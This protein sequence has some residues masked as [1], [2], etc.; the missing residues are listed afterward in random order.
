MKRAIETARPTAEA[1]GLA[2]EVEPWMRELEEWWIPGGPEG[3]CP[4][5]QVDGGTVRSLLPGLHQENWHS[6][7]PFDRPVLCEGF[8]ELRDHSAAFFARHGYLRDGRCYRKGTDEGGPLAVFCHGG[9]GLT[10]L[11]HLLEIPPPLLWTAFSL[12]PAS[13]TTV[14]LAE[15]ADGRA[16]PRCLGLADVAHLS[17]QK[18]L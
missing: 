5:W 10:W 4:V 6:L 11:A 14:E 17:D 18:T 3:E 9:F 13:V 15:L 12:P 7:P 16:V 1:L 8:A 2:I